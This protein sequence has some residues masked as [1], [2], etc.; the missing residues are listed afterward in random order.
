M[1]Q[2]SDEVFELWQSEVVNA[3]ETVNACSAPFWYKKNA[4]NNVVKLPKCMTLEK[5]LEHNMNMNKEINHKCQKLSDEN[6]ALRQELK[7]VKE[8]MKEIKS[9]L[10]QSLSHKRPAIDNITARGKQQKTVRYFFFTFIQYHYYF[11][12]YQLISFSY[13]T[14]IN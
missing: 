14:D 9:L 12:T 10:I 6:A 3:F 7:G 1:N 2:V 8:D 11:N 4:D 5:Y 13:I